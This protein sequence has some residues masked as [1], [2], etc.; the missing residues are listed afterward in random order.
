MKEAA[1]DVAQSN[2]LRI[3]RLTLKAT[4]TMRVTLYSSREVC[5]LMEGQIDYIFIITYVEFY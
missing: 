1:K 4:I 5:C 2:E 3:V